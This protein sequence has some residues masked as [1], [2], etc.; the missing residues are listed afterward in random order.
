MAAL[1][2]TDLSPLVFDFA[3][4]NWP[5]ECYALVGVWAKRRSE[6]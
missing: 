4:N 2:N 6:K 3:R 1:V 5:A